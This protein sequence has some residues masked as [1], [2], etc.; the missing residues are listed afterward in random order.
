MKTS[1]TCHACGQERPE[2]MIGVISRVHPIA[3][4][5]G[6]TMAENIRYCVDRPACEERARHISL[7]GEPGM[8]APTTVSSPLGRLRRWL[9]S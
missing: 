1:C 6:A 7:L 5:G 2:A 4:S 8:E 9:T 3:E